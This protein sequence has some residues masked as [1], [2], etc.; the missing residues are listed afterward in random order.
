MEYLN[1][2]REFIV[3][4][5]DVPKDELDAATNLIARLERLCIEFS[6]TDRN[7]LLRE[8]KELT[9]A[10]EIDELEGNALEKACE[11]ASELLSI[12]GIERQI[13]SD[14]LSLIALN[15]LVKGCSG[16]QIID[17]LKNESWFF[18][19]EVLTRWSWSSAQ[20]KAAQKGHP[21]N[22]IYL[23]EVGTSQG[24]RNLDREFF[25]YLIFMPH[26]QQ[27]FQKGYLISKYNGVE[28]YTSPDFISVDDDANQLGIEVTEVRKSDHDDFDAQ[29][30]EGLLSK[31]GFPGDAME[32]RT[33]Q[34]VYKRVQKKISGLQPAVRPCLLII[35][36]NMQF[37]GTDYKKLIELTK[38]ESGADIQAF[39]REIWLID[40]QQCIQLK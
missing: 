4:R 25:T 26:Y 32:Y 2:I 24:R 33:I 22:R 19:H 17:E 5:K 13:K 29:Q 39:F 3:K 15:Y 23:C 40:D 35:Y 8:L 37:L 28:T 20:K 27:R 18:K 38:E 10:H 31:N 21:F 12:E 7:R 6:K 1:E 30:K 11:V 34:A 16:G 36:D 14:T 9:Q